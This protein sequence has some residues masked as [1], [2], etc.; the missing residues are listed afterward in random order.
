MHVPNRYG[1]RRGVQASVITAGVHAWCRRVDAGMKVPL[2]RDRVPGT[3]RSDRK[4]SKPYSGETQKTW[5]APSPSGQGHHHRHQ[6][7]RLS[8]PSPAPQT[9]CSC[10]THRCTLRRHNAAA[11][12]FCPEVHQLTHRLRTLDP[13]LQASHK[14]WPVSPRHPSGRRKGGRS[15]G[16]GS[17]E[18]KGLWWETRDLHDLRSSQLT[19]R[20]TAQGTPA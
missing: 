3:L 2:S 13:S 5:P 8:H 17:L 11:V 16:R 19:P 12:G 18:L 9:R 15:A 14:H 10:H 4:Q 20:D 6:P 7:R 1:G